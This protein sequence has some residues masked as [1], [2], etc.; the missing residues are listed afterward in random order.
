ML[1]HPNYQVVKW[2]KML[3]HCFKHWSLASAAISPM[4]WLS[5]GTK[6]TW[7]GSAEIMLWLWKV[8]MSCSKYPVFSWKKSK[9][10]LEYVCCLSLGSFLAMSHATSTPSTILFISRHE[11]PML[12]WNK[13]NICGLQKHTNIFFF[14]APGLCLKHIIEMHNCN[15]SFDN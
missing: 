8:L 6:N 2:L 9:N 5:L 4:I 1:Q 15:S 12:M 10:N 3:K 11:S 7:L 13:W 14:L